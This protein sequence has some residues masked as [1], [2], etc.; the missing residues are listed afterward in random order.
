[1][2][3]RTLPATLDEINAGLHRGCRDVLAYAAVVAEFELAKVEQ[4]EVVVDRALSRMLT[5]PFAWDD[6]VANRVFVLW[7]T[8]TGEH[9]MQV[10]TLRHLLKCV[11]DPNEVV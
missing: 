5:D 2:I 8:G 10:L 6:T 1:M 7:R 9:Y 4:R 11:A 3:E